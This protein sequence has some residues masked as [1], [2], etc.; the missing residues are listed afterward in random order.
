[1]AD[2]YDVYAYCED[3]EGGSDAAYSLCSDGLSAEE[4]CAKLLETLKSNWG[5]TNAVGEVHLIIKIE[6]HKAE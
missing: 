5:L 2:S 1:M 3:E 6:R 4:V